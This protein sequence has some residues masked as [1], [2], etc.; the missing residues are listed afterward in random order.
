MQYND[1]KVPSSEKQV[2]LQIQALPSPQIYFRS[3]QLILILMLALAG[4]KEMA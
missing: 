4:K 3:G 2:T 1:G